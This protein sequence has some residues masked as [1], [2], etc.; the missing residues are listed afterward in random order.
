MIRDPITCKKYG[1]KGH[2][3]ASS[4]CPLN[5][6]KKKRQ[7]L[8]FYATLESPCHYKYYFFELVERGSSLER[9]LKKRIHIGLAPHKG[10]QENKYYVIVQKNNEKVRNS[11]TFNLCHF[12]LNK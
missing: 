5:G 10:Q 9:T 4:K 3:Q 8:F 6:T 2:R 11:N 1:E 12:T 7:V